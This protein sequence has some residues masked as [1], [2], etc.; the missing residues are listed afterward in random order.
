MERSNNKKSEYPQGSLLG[1]LLLNIFV[2]N[3]LYRMNGTEMFNYADGKALYL[4]NNTIGNVLQVL[5]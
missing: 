1:P 3:L 2:N 4:C 5:R